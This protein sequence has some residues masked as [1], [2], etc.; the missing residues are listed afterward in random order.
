MYTFHNDKPVTSLCA[1]SCTLRVIFQ[2]TEGVYKIYRLFFNHSGRTAAL[3]STQPLTERR[4][5]SLSWE[6]KAAGA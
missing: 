1:E 5:I 4:T 2:A 3:G 6:V